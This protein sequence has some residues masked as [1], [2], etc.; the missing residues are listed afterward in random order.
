M[1]IVTATTSKPI[2]SQLNSSIMHFR[3]T[4]PATAAIKT[5]V[6]ILSDPFIKPT[7]LTLIFAIKSS[8]TNTWIG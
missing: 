6:A 4:T 5:K 7:P 1:A 2:V 8:I 3:T